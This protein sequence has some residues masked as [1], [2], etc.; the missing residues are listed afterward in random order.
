MSATP[1]C[2]ARPSCAP[3]DGAGASSGR[4]RPAA[5]AVAFEDSVHGGPGDREQLGQFGDGVF[6]GGVQLHL[7]AQP[8]HTVS[9]IARLLGVSRSTI[10]KYVPDIAPGTAIRHDQDGGPSALVGAVVDQPATAMPMPAPPRA[11]DC[12]TCRYHPSSNHQIAQHREVETVWLF[13]DPD[14]GDRLIQRWHCSR[15]QAH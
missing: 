2:W 12:P 8:D 3:R 5:N 7:L 1:W 14:H 9:S 6:A 11:L 15:C 4:S 10:Y 13:A